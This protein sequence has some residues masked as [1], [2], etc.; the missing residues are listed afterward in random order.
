MMRKGKADPEVQ[1]KSQEE[2][3]SKLVGI[4]I[5]VDVETNRLLSAILSLKG[6]TLSGFLQDSIKKFIKENYQEAKELFDVYGTGGLGEGGKPP[7]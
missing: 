7:Q 6:M 2:T 1:S 4:T 5:R 3:K